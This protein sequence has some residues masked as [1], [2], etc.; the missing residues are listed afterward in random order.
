MRHLS[1]LPLLLTLTRRAYW[2]CNC[3]DY[4]EE[5]PL[6]RIRQRLRETGLKRPALEPAW[7]LW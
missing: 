2:Y 7:G 1:A 4:I 6:F 3:G 5:T